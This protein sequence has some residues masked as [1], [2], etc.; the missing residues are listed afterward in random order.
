M[1]E[2][3]YMVS[4]LKEEYEKPDASDEL[5]EEYQINLEMVAAMTKM[6]EEM[7]KNKDERDRA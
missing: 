2:Y 7:T 5:K 4:I 3:E 1:E 6:I